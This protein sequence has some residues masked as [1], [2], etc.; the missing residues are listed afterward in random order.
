MKN[1]HAIQSALHRFLVTVLC[2]AAVVGG[3]PAHTQAQVYEQIFS[4]TDPRLAIIENGLNKGAYP[5]AGLVQGLDG[6]FYGTT[7]SGGASDLGTV[8]KMTP[9]GVLTTL[10]EFTGNGTSNKGSSPY[11]A[12]VEGND[13]NFYGTTSGGGA[14]NLG[15]VFKITPRGVLTTL[16]EFTGIGAP[17]TGSGPQAALVQGS[18]GNFYGTTASGGAS[19]NGTVFKMTPTGALTTLVEFTGNGATNKGSNPY[20]ELVQG[21]DSNFYG[22]TRGGGAFGGGTVFR[23]TPDGVLVTL[24]ELKPQF[25]YGDVTRTGSSPSAPL[26]LGS[27]GNFY[28][29]TEFGGLYEDQGTVFKMTPQGVLT[30]LVDIGGRARYG[31]VQGV[32]GNLYGTVHNRAGA[33]GF[34]RA[35]KMTPDG[36]LST[37][38]DFTGTVGPNKGNRPAGELIL[39]RD[40]NFYGT[41]AWGG[42][43]FVGTVFKMTAGGVLT[44]LVEFT[45]NITNAIDGGSQS[46]LVEGRDGNFYGTVSDGGALAAGTVNKLTPA[47]ALTTLVEFTGDGLTNQGAGPASGLVLGSDGDFYGTTSTSDRGGRGTVFKMR[48]L[49]DNLRDNLNGRDGV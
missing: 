40:R 19:N 36:V 18:D 14:A 39:G 10:V 42:A 45:G 22:N 32:D 9:G 12:L 34:G 29:T 4:F 20:S 17:N 28:G 38:F 48:L 8:F 41:T 21:T 5:Y 27:D 26:V 24:V 1:L 16:V 13:G 25:R 46:A 15:T 11:S 2:D 33:L 23:V 44:T 6:N 3:F 37:L 7:A 31:L 49:R 43:F 35:F 30:T 47:G